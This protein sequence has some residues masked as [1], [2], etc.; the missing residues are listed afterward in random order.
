MNAVCPKY[1]NRK[2]EPHLRHSVLTPFAFSVVRTNISTGAFYDSVE[3][4]AILTPM[5]GVID[6]FESFLDGDISGE[7]MEVGPKGGFQQ[8][9]PAEH[10]DAESGKVMALL[11]HRGHPLHEPKK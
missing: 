2:V 5:K 4:Q 11:Y 9:A 8:R 3:E 7:C 6:A 10:L 1:V